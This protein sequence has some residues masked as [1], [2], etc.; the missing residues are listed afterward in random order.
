MRLSDKNYCTLS[1]LSKVFGILLIC[2][3]L[4]FCGAKVSDPQATGTRPPLD[5]QIEIEELSSNSMGGRLFL[6]QQQ[7]GYKHKRCGMCHS[8]VDRGILQPFVEQKTDRINPFTGKPFE[9]IEAIC[10]TCHSSLHL[11]HPV[12]IIPNPEKVVL[13]PEAK[14]FKGEEDCLTCMSCHDWHPTNNNYKYLR[15]PVTDEEDL[16]RF[17][18][19]CHTGQGIKGEEMVRESNAQKVFRMTGLANSYLKNS[20]VEKNDYFKGYQGAIF[21]LAN[22]TQKQTKKA[23][24]NEIEIA[25]TGYRK[26]AMLQIDSAKDNKEKQ[27]T[28]DYQAQP[29][30][31]ESSLE[32]ARDTTALMQERV[33]R[34][35]ETGRAYKREGELNNAI[36]YFRRAIEA[37]HDFPQ[38]YCELGEIYVLK[39]WLDEAKSMF[40]KAIELAPDFAPVYLG[41]SRL[42]KA[43]GEYS[44][45]VE[46]CK[47][48]LKLKPNYSPAYYQ[49]GLLYKQDGKLDKAQQMIMQAIDSSDTPYPAAYYELGLFYKQTDLAKAQELFSLTIQ[50]TEHAGAYYELG[51]IHKRAGDLSSAMDMF[52]RAVAAGSSDPRPY[53][54]LACLYKQQ[55]LIDEA[56]TAY[57]QATKTDKNFACAYY[58]L[59]VIFLENQQLA[60]ATKMLSQATKINPDYYEAY[61]QLAKAYYQQKKSYRAIKL[62]EK[63]I[64]IKQDYAE[65]FF[66]LGK[67]YRQLGKLND[68][69]ANLKQVI[70]LRPKHAQAH[71]LL[72]DLYK[73]KGRKTEAEKE[74]QLAIKFSQPA[75]AALSESISP[76][77]KMIATNKIVTSLDPENVDAFYDLGTAYMAVGQLKEAVTAYLRVIELKPQHWEA[78]YNLALAY[79]IQNNWIEA[80]S[81]IQN[82]IR[83][84]PDLIDARHAL[85]E[86]LQYQGRWEQAIQEFKQ[87]LS[88]KPASITYRIAQIYYDQWLANKNRD[89]L[90]QAKEYFNQALKHNPKNIGARNSLQQ[91]EK[92]LTTEDVRDESSD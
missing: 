63:T 40:Q 60:D 38:I 70:A 9:R 61:F 90:V 33:K 78:H 69:I 73:A 51:E 85:A 54:E 72:G 55:G 3:M 49:L 62:Y 80:T 45:A 84:K 50:H 88:H 20:K 8:V 39:G 14:G 34:N 92:I 31:P 43:N 91:I 46:V 26:T 24:S 48:A 25:K 86:I 58:Q 5:S 30:N 68:S 29:E 76:L 67:C 36:I 59:G 22:Y 13:P 64:A 27:K 77:N 87:I 71:Y 44:Q 16:N 75:D 17:C 18:L 7:S 74:F 1:S 23:K 57:T 52:S 11:A 12:G 10:T 81:A 4:W 21:N 2:P 82:V 32:L 66:E 6:T 56:I 83:M 65:A 19:N 79:K 42:Y 89:A 41:L 15:W 53:Y 37:G 47:T 28:T 35:Y